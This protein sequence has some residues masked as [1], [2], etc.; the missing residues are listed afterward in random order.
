MKKLTA[1]FFTSIYLFNLA[2]YKLVFDY[3]ILQ[4][5][6]EIVQQLDD[7][8]YDESSLIELKVVLRLPYPVSWNTYERFDGEIEID[9]VQYNFVKRKWKEDTLFVMC[10]PNHSKTELARAKQDYQ[11]QNIDSKTT[12][13]QKKNANPSA[14]K[15]NIETTCKPTGVFDLQP[16]YSNTGFYK[17]LIPPQLILPFFDSLFKPPRQQVTGFLIG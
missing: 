7:A 5:D 15:I 17:S 11:L 1:I 9:G 14:K 4:N 16:V 2:G 13:S 10:L 12:P 6:K 8:V 3:L